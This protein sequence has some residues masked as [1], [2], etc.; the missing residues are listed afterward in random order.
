MIYIE[1]DIHVHMYTYFK[2]LLQTQSDNQRPF[3]T[4]AIS[5]PTPNTT[6]ALYTYICMYICPYY[7]Y[8]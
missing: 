5:S 3:Q 1:I 8:K 6:R 2:V 7:I 4:P